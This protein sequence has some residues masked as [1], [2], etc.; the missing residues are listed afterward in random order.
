MT[1][2]AGKNGPVLGIGII[3]LG[4]AARGMI[5]KFAHRDNVRIAA[6][7]DVDAEI[8]GRFAKDFP[9]A[10]TY[11]S[12]EGLVASPKVDWV[13][14]AT[15]NRFHSE[16]ARLALE[17]K[18]HVL[19]EKP[20]TITLE[21]ADVMID[22]ADR[23]GVL[24][25]VNVK[26]SFEPRVTKLRQMVSSGELGELRMINSWRYADWLYR[27]RTPEELTPGWGGGA[28]WRQGPHQLDILR[29]IAGGLVRSVRGLAG[30][31]DA[32]RRV[33]GA[34]VAYLDFEEGTVATAVF[35]GYDHYNSRELVYG[36][37]SVDRGEHANA[38][39][40]LRAAPDANWEENAARD[41]RYGGGRQSVQP[42]AANP[43]APSGGWILGGP[44]MASFDHADVRM[45]P[46]GLD[47]YGDE[48]R[49][50]IELK[51]PKDGRDGRIESFYDAIVNGR[52]LP[53]DGRWGK[54]TLEVLLAIE[55]SSEK[56]A[57]V[58]LSHQ[59]KTVE[60]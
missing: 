3:G 60:L 9:D 18:K 50:E 5:S 48:N 2:D 42:R 4:G 7:A 19:I 56:R 47:I 10:E 59:A 14:I 36:M 31:W 20:M 43:D 17:S 57:E 38:R 45:S 6:A 1:T 26:H 21:A 35:S 40:E 51:G 25:G 24:L 34:H 29:T 55:E 32:S 28:L 53:A 23:N 8:L 30:T 41:E 13:Y 33:P 54:A 37:G 27:P 12:A 52:S 22:A 11:D 15:P 46:N 16:H 39:A 49:W 58:H 44:M